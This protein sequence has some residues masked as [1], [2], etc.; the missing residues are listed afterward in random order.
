MSNQD[1]NNEKAAAFERIKQSA[2]HA[3]KQLG[4]AF[5]SS[6]FYTTVGLVIGFGLLATQKLLVQ[7][8]EPAAVSHEFWAGLL[9]LLA[10]IS[11]HLGIGFIVAAITVFF[12]E[13]GAHIKKTMALAAGLTRS[14]DQIEETKTIITRND[15]VAAA[16]AQTKRLMESLGLTERLYKDIDKAT[17]FNLKVCLNG[18]IGG[19]SKPRSEYSDRAI[20]SCERLILAIQKLRQDGAWGNDKYIEFITK[21]ISDVVGHNAEGLSNLRRNG[22]KQDF[23]VPPTAAGM[24]AEILSK[25]MEAMEEGDSYDVISDLTSWQDSQLDELLSTAET[26]VKSDKVQ[27][28]RVFNLLPYT[29]RGPFKKTLPAKY[30]EILETHLKASEMWKGDKGIGCYLVKILWRDGYESLRKDP[31]WRNTEIERLHFGLF[32]HTD[33]S[34]KFSVTKSDLSDMEMLRRSRKNEDERLFTA[35]WG[36]ARNFPPEGSTK[37]RI[38]TVC[39]KLQREME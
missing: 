8:S 38:Q 22:N 30:D 2:R 12:Y 7:W 32:G 14:I 20:E 25:Q 23:R 29:I 34:V 28:R 21:H 3:G 17:R 15:E 18:L 5:I 24:A 35:L 19:A 4:P 37:E 16:L 33:E 11:E 13:W 26:A 1:D 27:I 39:A 36:A 10:T 6:W 31:R 9:H